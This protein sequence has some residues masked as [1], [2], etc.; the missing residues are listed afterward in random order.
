MLIATSRRCHLMLML[1][2][3]A[4]HAHLMI[5]S[6]WSLRYCRRFFMP[7]MLLFL[8]LLRCC[9]ISS[10]LF[11]YIMARCCRQLRRFSII[12]PRRCH[13]RCAAFDMLLD[14]DY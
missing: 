3:A 9:F 14:A 12:T 11:R 13:Y 8:P 5:S 4:F 10:A 1:I 2:F 7:P 6:L